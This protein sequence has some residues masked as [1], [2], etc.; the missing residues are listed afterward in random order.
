VGAYA[1]PCYIAA[2]EAI[3]CLG[4]DPAETTLISFGTGT[5]KSGLKP[6]EATD[7]WPWEWLDPVMGAFLQSA[8]EE[9]VQVVGTLFPTLDFRRFQVTLAESIGMDAAD[10][11]P[12]LV[13]YGDEMGQKV[14]NDDTEPIPSFRAVRMPE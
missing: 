6:G 4:W 14:L 12:R 8:Y 1:N 2:Y 13:D 9:Q 7:F 10:Q 11:I 3:H 5:I